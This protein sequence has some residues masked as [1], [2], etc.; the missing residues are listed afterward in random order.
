MKRY[1]LES[2]EL[3][4]DLERD[5]ASKQLADSVR[6]TRARESA[7]E[8]LRANQRELS[9]RSERQSV[10]ERERAV[11]DGARAADFQQ[12]GAYELG[13]RTTL[14]ALARS[15]QEERQKLREA[16][17]MEEL[18]RGE[19]ARRDAD[20]RAVVSHRQRFEA[21]LRAKTERLAEE[22]ADAIHGARRRR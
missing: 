7:V 2:L 21:E 22:D 13:I 8:T 12:L 4:R 11:A 17:A 6:S 5:Q 16:Q 9:E 19:L 10:G 15:E 3:L 20:R 18:A 14:S 1:P